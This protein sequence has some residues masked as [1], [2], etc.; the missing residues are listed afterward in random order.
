MRRNFRF[1]S[2]EY[3]TSSKKNTVPKASQ[4]T[5]EKEGELEQEIVNEKLEADVEEEKAI[6]YGADEYMDYFKGSSKEL[7]SLHKEIYSIQPA[8]LSGPLG[9][10]D[11]DVLLFIILII[12]LQSP[13]KDFSLILIILLLIINK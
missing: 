13:R 1:T 3:E 9:Y 2:N 11:E 8:K 10:I 6:E 4:E 7:T 12:L 5:E